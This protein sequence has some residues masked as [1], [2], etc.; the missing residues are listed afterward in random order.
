MFYHF[1]RFRGNVKLV[2][3]DL[4]RASRPLRVGQLITGRY[5]GRDKVRALRFAL[6]RNPKATWV[7]ALQSAPHLATVLAP[8]V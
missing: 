1:N 3:F 8:R 4:A 7:R 6:S 5:M 2:T